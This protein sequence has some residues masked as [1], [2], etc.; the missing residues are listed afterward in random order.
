MKVTIKQVEEIVS[1]LTDEQKQL[2]KDTIKFGHG[3]IQLMSSLQRTEK[4]K[5]CQ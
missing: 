4:P 1:V 5:R 3:V 2:L